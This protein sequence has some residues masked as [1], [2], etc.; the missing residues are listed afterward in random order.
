MMAHGCDPL[1]RCSFL[2][3]RPYGLEIKGI[4]PT[5]RLIKRAKFINL[6]GSTT[7][8]S[9]PAMNSGGA[10]DVHRREETEASQRKLLQL[11][12]SSFT[13]TLAH[14][15]SNTITDQ[16]KQSNPIRERNINEKRLTQAG[17]IQYFP[18]PNNITA[19]I[20]IG[21]SRNL[22]ALEPLDGNQAFPPH[23]LQNPAFIKTVLQLLPHFSNC[24]INEPV[25]KGPILGDL[26]NHLAS[27]NAHQDPIS[28]DLLSQSSQHNPRI[29][30]DI[31]SLPSSPH[32]I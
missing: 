20:N 26:N 13:T 5:A 4:P 3:A 10:D 7:G 28:N 1:S 8:N 22:S 29:T 24:S 16:Q 31:L 9:P 18:I 14:T 27:Q 21:R 15:P 6:R 32:Y 30:N 17:K 2:L 23:I 11:P 25:T 19:D 12:S